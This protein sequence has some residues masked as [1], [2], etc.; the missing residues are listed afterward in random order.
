MRQLTPR[1]LGLFV[2]PAPA[3][4]RCQG[5]ANESSADKQQGAWLRHRL[6]TVFRIIS[7]SV[8]LRNRFVAGRLS[9]VFE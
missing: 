2:D 3:P 5:D 6:R 4:S 9:V 8:H 7:R 1:L